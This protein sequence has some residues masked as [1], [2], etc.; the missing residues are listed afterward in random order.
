[1]SHTISSLRSKSYWR[2]A[3][4]SR[5]AIAKILSV[6]GGLYLLIEVLDFFQVYTRD[7]YS[8]Y[9]ILIIL[10][11]SVLVV[12]FTRRPVSK[13]SYKIPN[14]DQAVA[15][16]VGDLFSQNGALV[17][18]TSTTFD[19]DIAGGTISPDSLQ[20]QV[21]LKYFSGATAEIDRQIE[22][23]LN[24]ESWVDSG[25]NDRKPKEFKLG[26]VASVRGEGK[27]FY[28]TAMSRWNENGNAYSSV[29]M[30]DEALEGLWEYCAQKGELVDI[31]IPLMGTGRGRIVLPQKKVI[32][33][34][35]Q[36]FLYASS[37]KVFAKK[38]TIVVRAADAE[39]SDLN[40]FQVRDYLVES[41]HT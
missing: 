32:E 7:K 21:A 25:R 19:T 41:L 11:V 3:I 29:S 30:L 10:A 40:L 31:A 17:V 6:A 20:G 28:F 36:S 14:R 4:F 2:Y 8:K 12:L 37:E 1:M 5:A 38:L 35:A 13:V 9:A 27:T 18:S 26:A 16:V 34:I 15:V 23:S 22:A 33:R 39:V 24:G